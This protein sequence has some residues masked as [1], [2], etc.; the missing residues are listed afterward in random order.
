MSLV[1]LAL[2]V[3]A[4][5]ARRGCSRRLGS[6]RCGLFGRDRDERAE[7]AADAARLPLDREPIRI[8]DARHLR[9]L[10]LI[11]EYEARLA[12]GQR[13]ASS[14]ENID[15]VLVA[16]H[17]EHDLSVACGDVLG[18]TAQDDALRRRAIELF[19]RSPCFVRDW[20]S[21]CV[22]SLRAHAGCN[23]QQYRADH[24]C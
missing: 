5:A 12:L 9:A 18:D 2:L 6:E 23:R 4:R 17:V 3:A 1:R 14:V 21:L 22:L 15:V 13:L 7:R 10:V 19:L 8:A 24:E 16:L 20:R 11:H